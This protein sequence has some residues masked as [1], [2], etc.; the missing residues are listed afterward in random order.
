MPRATRGIVAVTVVP[1][2]GGLSTRSRPPRGGE[3][4]SQSEQ[5]RAEGVGAAAPVVGNVQPDGALVAADVISIWF[6]PA[7]LTAL[8]S[9][10]EHT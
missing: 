8:A 2:S 6:A 9:A 7:C 5:A 1:T 10:S 4:V 3:A